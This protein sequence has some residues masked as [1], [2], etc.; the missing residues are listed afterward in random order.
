MFCKKCGNKIE[1][2]YNFC[3]FCGTKI[4]LSYKKETGIY[5]TKCNS[6]VSFEDKYCKNCGYEFLKTEDKYDYI[7]IDELNSKNNFSNDDKN[8]NK[9][10]SNLFQNNE[11][12]NT[13]EDSMRDY[14]TLRLMGLK[15]LSGVKI[16]LIVQLVILSGFL[17][18]IL[19]SSVQEANILY[20]LGYNNS[21]IYTTMWLFLIFGGAYIF[22][23]SIT[24]RGINLGFRPYTIGLSRFCLIVFYIFIFFPFSLIFWFL[25]SR[26]NNSIAKLWCGSYERL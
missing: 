4:D 9:D 11:H 23:L 24:I 16:L 20:L 21:D 1:E 14:A 25:W 12:N 22:I 15:L 6:K 2:S 13:L 10:N 8:E 5:C 26:L 3:K 7:N 17:L 19:I 18:Y